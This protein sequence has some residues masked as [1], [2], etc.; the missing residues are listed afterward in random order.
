MVPAYMAASQ[1]RSLL[2]CA[3]K[4]SSCRRTMLRQ[5]ELAFIKAMSMLQPSP[6]LLRELRMALSQRR[7]KPVVLAGSRGTTSGG[8]ARVPSDHLVSS[9]NPQ[10]ATLGFRT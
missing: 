6:T 3:V 9:L 1:I 8:G 5:E 7:K 2:S 4:R 10:K